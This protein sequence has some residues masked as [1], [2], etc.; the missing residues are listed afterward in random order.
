M[1]IYALLDSNNLVEDLIVLDPRNATQ[2]F[3]T[4][5]PTDGAGVTTGDTYDPEEKH[6]F[7]NGTKL[8]NITEKYDSIRCAEGIDTV[9]EILYG[10][11]P[12]EEDTTDES[13]TT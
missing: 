9:L 13:T 6:F 10:I 1:A 12:E 2:D 4:A 7:R 5:V 11:I 3:P 8:L